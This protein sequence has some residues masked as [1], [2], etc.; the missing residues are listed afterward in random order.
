MPSVSANSWLP[1]PGP[2]MAGMPSAMAER[3]SGRNRA[4]AHGCDSLVKKLRIASSS[5]S[6]ST[7]RQRLAWLVWR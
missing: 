5:V 6:E 1:T 2:G 7:A 4:Q 3:G